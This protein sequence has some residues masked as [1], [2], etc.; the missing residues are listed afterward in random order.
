[1]M[2]LTFDMM[3]ATVDG[4]LSTDKV[5]EN[6]KKNPTVT[7]DPHRATKSSQRLRQFTTKIITNK[8]DLVSITMSDCTVY[9][10]R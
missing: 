7:T 1:M 4:W 3:T 2:R 10:Y 5:D 9:V 6:H 8:A